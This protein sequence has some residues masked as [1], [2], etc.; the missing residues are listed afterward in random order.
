M[1]HQIVLKLLSI[2][3]HENRSSLLELSNTYILAVGANLMGTGHGCENT[4]N[5]CKPKNSDAINENSNRRANV[6]PRI[7]V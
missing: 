5:V 7:A 1:C 4:K 3:F 6:F 2:Q